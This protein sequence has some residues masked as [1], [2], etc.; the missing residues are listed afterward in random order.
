MLKNSYLQVGVTKI[1]CAKSIRKDPR[2]L[3]QVKKQKE[4]SSEEKKE[5][6]RSMF[7]LRKYRTHGT[8]RYHGRVAQ[9]ANYYKNF[10]RFTRNGG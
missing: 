7:K 3:Q 6:Q 8:P 10:M 4:K 2:D 1:L 9:M 5:C